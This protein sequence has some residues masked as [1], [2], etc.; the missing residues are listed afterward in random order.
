MHAY[1]VLVG[2]PEKKRPEYNTKM[3]LREA[4]GRL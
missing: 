2:K 1:N 4:D 3:N